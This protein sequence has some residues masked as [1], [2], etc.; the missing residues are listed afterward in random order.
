MAGRSKTSGTGTGLN[1][2]TTERLRNVAQEN[3]GGVLLVVI[4]KLNDKGQEYPFQTQAYL[5]VDQIEK[6][7]FQISADIGG[8]GEYLWRIFTT[9]GRRSAPSEMIKV[10]VDGIP[11]LDV[12]EMEKRMRQRDLGA[13]SR[14]QNGNGIQP[15]WNMP[16]ASEM[17]T[18]RKKDEPVESNEVKL[19]R[20]QLEEMKD[21][22]R[23]EEHRRELDAIKSQH[24]QEMDTLAS[25]LDRM[26]DLVQREQNKP[27]PEPKTNIAETISAAVPLIVGY[28]ES[29]SKARDEQMKVLTAAMGKNPM[30]ELQPILDQN[31]KVIESSREEVRQLQ[32][33][34]FE[35]AN[36]DTT[37]SHVQLFQAMSQQQQ[38]F[39]GMISALLGQIAEMSQGERESPWV[40]ALRRLVDTADTAIGG[41]MASMAQQQH[42]Q[43]PVPPRPQLGAASIS[44]QQP[45]PV[46]PAKATAEEKI[47]YVWNQIVE[48]LENREEP[49]VVAGAVIQYCEFLKQIQ[50]ND[51][52]MIV[53]WDDQPAG[54]RRILG[55]Y[56][57]QLGSEGSEY[58][59]AII[60]A[61]P[62]AMEAL[63]QEREAA[64]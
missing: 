14:P 47:K 30:A 37:S 44:E 11:P 25:K 62:E 40:E 43:P 3:G 39:S 41:V 28:M 10:S 63:A 32:K 36:K 21:K 50:P 1:S 6:D 64:R 58:L 55:S 22:A 9:D 17:Y 45:E 53:F 56:M 15:F 61:L 38:A 23:R 42:Q 57:A 46:Q 19:L 54:T 18:S 12:E 31:N 48:L 60:A 52:D 13:Q 24:K 8:G 4:K 5:T 20:Q 49:V 16:P 34:F 29:Q 2:E 33:M 59:E 35:M 51:V 7:R 27:P 26:V